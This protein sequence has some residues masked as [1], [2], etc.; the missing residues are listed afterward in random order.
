MSCDAKSRIV[1][2]LAP[3]SAVE[4]LL[5]IIMVLLARGVW[6]L[7]DVL[8]E[9][10]KLTEE[11]MKHKGSDERTGFR[12]SRNQE[13]KVPKQ[14]R[15]TDRV[16]RTS[17]KMFEHCMLGEHD[18]DVSKFMD[19]CRWYGDKVLT[20]MGTFTLV[21]VREIHANMDKVKQTYQLDPEKHRS[22]HEILDA[23]CASGMHQPGGV[24]SDPSAAM[25]LL[26]ARRGLLFWVCL[27]R[28]HKDQDDKEAPPSTPTGS[29]S[30]HNNVIAAYEEA[31]A[32]FNGWVT[33]NTF[34][35]AARAFPEWREIEATWA[36]T[37]EEAMADM[38]GWVNVLDPLLERM[39]KIISSLDL[40]DKRKSI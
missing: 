18:M 9:Q 10:R 24:L 1:L 5:I 7:S 4:V 11:R 19:A 31:L 23:E 14:P 26:W 25:G 36:S 13:L 30:Y 2:E 32:P 17:A 37:H 27:F 29:N 8:V 28:K 6:L 20:R 21:T 15:S 33:R 3:F 12:S 38:T 40:E 22:M 16:L 34:M 35:L 39:G